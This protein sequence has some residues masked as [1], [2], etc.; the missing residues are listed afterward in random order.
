LDLAR[1]REGGTI[2][3]VPRASITEV[4]PPTAPVFFNPAASLNRDVTVAVAAAAECET[5][6]DSMAGVGARGVRVANEVERVAEVVMVDFNRDALKLARRSAS[7][8]GVKR[9]CAFAESETSSYLYSRFGRN[10][11]F[12]CV[13]LDPFG[14]PI[15]QIQAA[16]SA[17]ADGGILSVTATDTAVLCGVHL[18]TCAR[19]YG[20][21]PINNHFHHETGMRI[22]LASLARSAASMD[23]GIEPVVAHSTRHYLRVFVRVNPGAASADSSLREL[24]HV[25]WCPACGEVMSS[26][27]AQGPCPACG[28]KLKVAGPL[29][30]GSVVQEPLIK[31][32][33][34]EALERELPGAV[35]ILESLIGVN[36]FPPWSYDIDQI[37]SELKVPTTSELSVYTRLIQGGHRVMR[38]PFEKS[39]V[40]TDAGYSEVVDAVR[41]ASA[42]ARQELRASGPR[43]NSKARS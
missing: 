15:R 41:S 2:L 24:G 21:T 43:S 36:G 17:T 16:L 19:R 34:K 31:A 7:L 23:I 38:T 9:K 10:Q 42:E 25:A 37:C 27:E 29:W 14:T 12:D 1:Y 18:S 6:C 40:K 26:R 28:E 4:P 11:R 33:R 30:A 20:S 13:D 35:G 8:N 32:A 39:G 22:L 5:F 3:V